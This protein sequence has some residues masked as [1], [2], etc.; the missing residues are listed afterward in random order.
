MDS[1]LELDGDRLHY[2]DD[3]VGPVLLMLHGNLTSSVFYADIIRELREDFRCVAL[4]YPGFG[5]S[6]ARPGFG[7]TIAEQIN[8]VARFV[9]H[10]NLQDVTPVMWEWGGPIGFALAARDPGRYRAFV[11]ANTWAWPLAPGDRNEWFARVASSP[12]V[13]RAVCAFP[14]LADIALRAAHRRRRLTAVEIQERRRP[15]ATS[16]GRGRVVTFAREVVAARPV[17][18]TVER[19]LPTL[20]QL[21]VLIIWARNDM[22]FGD[23]VKRRFESIFSNR[24]TIEL[25]GVGHHVMDDAPDDVARA[26]RSWHAQMLRV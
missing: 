14:Y 11:I 5:R 18:E 26:I 20:A 3:G 22:A 7:Y 16:V 23:E 21:P 6:T 13:G 12:V 15:F 25:D 8:V 4:D 19:A 10:L 9:T 17:L 24:V 1:F 2:R